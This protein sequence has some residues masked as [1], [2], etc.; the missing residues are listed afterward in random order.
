MM[1]ASFLLLCACEAAR[2]A[3]PRLTSTGMLLLA[4][5]PCRKTFVGRFFV[6]SLWVG[7]INHCAVVA[8]VCPVTVVVRQWPCLPPCLLI[9]IMP[10]T[11]PQSLLRGLLSQPEA[12]GSK[13]SA[14]CFAFVAHTCCLLQH[15]AA[16]Q[17]SRNVFESRWPTAAW[18]ASAPEDF[19]KLNWAWCGQ[20][21][22]NEEQE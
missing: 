16:G 10:A 11:H 19:R 21:A 22:S 6:K 15:A 9:R 17:P 20:G 3:S 12:P 7:S 4:S 2:Q 5:Q 18:S 8:A 1:A 14:V 13:W